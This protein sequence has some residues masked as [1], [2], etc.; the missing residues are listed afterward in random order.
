[1]L[2]KG[3][4]KLVND[5]GR[6]FSE[7]EYDRKLEKYRGVKSPINLVIC[8]DMWVGNFERELIGYVFGILDGVQQEHDF[9]FQERLC[10]A[11]EVFGKTT[12]IDPEE[13]E[14]ELLDRYLFETFQS[15]DDWEQI[16]FYNVETCRGN[17]ESKIVIQFAE[18]PPIKWTSIFIPRI[19]KFFEQ[20]AST[21]AKGAKIT[22]MYFENISK[23]EK[24]HYI[25]HK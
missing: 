25:K 10:F 4:E 6:D 19:K 15:V 21:T 3:L 16:T 12:P 8:C 24:I 13:E 20:Y 11:K 18:I 23:N 17:T 5:Y 1:M 22:E 7:W 2:A 14:Y 9:A